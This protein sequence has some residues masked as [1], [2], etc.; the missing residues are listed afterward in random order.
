MDKIL[1]QRNWDEDETI[2]E[3]NP[4]KP[5]CHLKPIFF[6]KWNKSYLKIFKH[7][8]DLNFL[9]LSTEYKKNIL[10][11]QCDR[12]ERQIYAGC[13]EYFFITKHIIYVKA[14]SRMLGHQVNCCTQTKTHCKGGGE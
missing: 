14:L 10:I 8:N 7:L 1:T 5:Q 11:T 6:S 12:E 9:Y 4:V 2:S 3:F 13:Y